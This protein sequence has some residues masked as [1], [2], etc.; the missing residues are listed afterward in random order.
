MLRRR[1]FCLI[2]AQVKLWQSHWSS[3]LH[4]KELPEQRAGN[5]IVFNFKS[6]CKIF[7]PRLFD[8][9]HDRKPGKFKGKARFR[10]RTSKIQ[11]VP[12]SLASGGVV[13][14]GLPLQGLLTPSIFAV[15]DNMKKMEPVV[16]WP[17][18]PLTFLLLLCKSKAGLLENVMGIKKVLP[19]VT[20]HIRTELPGYELTVL[21]AHWK[22]WLQNAH[23]AAQAQVLCCSPTQH[24]FILHDGVRRHELTGWTSNNFQEFLIHKKSFVYSH[25]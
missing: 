11:I 24:P 5:S 4:P 15:V 14:R 1:G 19:E 9:V 8:D 3:E 23:P 10:V 20:Q 22:I 12:S 2:D 21:R 18:A 7:A 13:H 6:E 17:I 16:S 25:S